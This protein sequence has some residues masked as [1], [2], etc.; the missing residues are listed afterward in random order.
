[1]SDSYYEEVYQNTNGVLIP[2]GGQ[3]LI[4][5][6]YTRS[7]KFFIQKSL[8]AAEVGEIYPIWATC[9]GFEQMIVLIGK[10]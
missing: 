1:M 9:L 8:L 10:S 7:A 6:T 3:N 5:S 2:G 4:N